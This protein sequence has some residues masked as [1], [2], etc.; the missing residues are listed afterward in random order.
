MLG[1]KLEQG[2]RVSFEDNDRTNLKPSNIK[3]TR[4]GGGSLE[5]RRGQ[6]E[7]RIQ[8]LQA[9]LDEVNEQIARSKV[10]QSR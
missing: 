5:R 3:V 10:T 4:Y 8:E 2:E 1:R 6:L 7:A 9:E